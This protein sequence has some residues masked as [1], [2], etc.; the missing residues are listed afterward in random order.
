MNIQNILSTVSLK[1]VINPIFHERKTMKILKYVYTSP[2]TSNGKQMFPES[3][4]SF[5]KK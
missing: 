5:I 2:H 1:E 3:E 4:Y